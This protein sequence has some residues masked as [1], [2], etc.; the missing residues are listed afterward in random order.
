MTVDIKAARAEV[1]ER[2]KTLRLM[3]N[4][5]QQ[6]L[7]DKLGVSKSI[8]SAYEKGIRSPSFESL[9]YLSDVFGVEVGRLFGDQIP[10][11]KLYIDFTKFDVEDL[12]ILAKMMTKYQNNGED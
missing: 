11:K 7:A 2:I 12:E 6:E 4:L 3:M 5:T 1:G 9:I 8:I 10:P